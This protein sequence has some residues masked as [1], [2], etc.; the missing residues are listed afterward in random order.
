MVDLGRWLDE[1]YTLPIERE[2][3]DGNEEPSP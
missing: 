1:G 2:D 3:G